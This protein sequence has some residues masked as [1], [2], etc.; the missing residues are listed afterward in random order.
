M[1]ENK[2]EYYGE[3]LMNMSRM[4]MIVDL[5][6][7]LAALPKMICESVRKGDGDAPKYAELYE[8][9]LLDQ[10]SLQAQ[11][12]ATSKELQ[13]AQVSL[14]CLPKETQETTKD[15]R[16]MMAGMLA[17][18]MHMTS[19]T[20]IQTAIAR[21]KDEHKMATDMDARILHIEDVVGATWKLMTAQ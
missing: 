20:E 10:H 8:R 3:L 21:W 16:E 12:E 17:K 7:A 11:Y 13:E 15:E 19:I 14:V 18:F 1:I 4:R 6:D 2:S 9:K 5:S